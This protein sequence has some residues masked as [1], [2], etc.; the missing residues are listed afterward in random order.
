MKIHSFIYE[1]IFFSLVFLF[2]FLPPFFTDASIV[3]TSLFSTWNFPFQQLGLCIFAVILYYFFKRTF[4]VDYTKLFHS[5]FILAMLFFTALLLK[6]FSILVGFSNESTAKVSLP[7]SILQ[8]L[9]CLLQFLFS[10]VYEEVLYRFYFSD[11]L[12]S[13]TKGLFPKCKGKKTHIFCELSGVLVFA[14]AH[15]YLG[16]L[17]VINGAFAHIVLRLG[18]KKTDNLLCCILAHFFYNIISL[19]LL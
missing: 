17:A 15:F 9:F 4:K 2:C 5:I 13:V 7:K 11:E 19:I 16:W 10:A 3:G 12:F 14:F 8:W 6:G 1:I 18:Y